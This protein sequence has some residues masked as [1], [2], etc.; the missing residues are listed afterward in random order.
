[1]NSLSEVGQEERGAPARQSRDGDVH[2]TLIYISTLNLYGKVH[3]GV[4]FGQ[5]ILSMDC[6]FRT[7]NQIDVFGRHSLLNNVD[8]LPTQSHLAPVEVHAP[9]KFVGCNFPDV[10][11]S[12]RYRPSVNWGIERSAARR[13][14]EVGRLRYRMHATRRSNTNSHGPQTRSHLIDFRQQIV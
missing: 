14:P 8:F 2:Y 3:D 1:M 10:A 4:D 5:Q 7:Q 12:Y 9:L 13:G 6:R 11:E